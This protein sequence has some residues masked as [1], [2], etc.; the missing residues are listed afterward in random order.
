MI[1]IDDNGNFVVTATNHLTTTATSPAQNFKAEVRCIQG[2]W[3]PDQTF[4]RNTLIWTLSQSVG[5][6][7][8]DLIRIGTKYMTVIAVSYDPQTQQYSVQA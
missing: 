1:A 5:D 4:G 3:A 8:A 6:R 7:C 2:T